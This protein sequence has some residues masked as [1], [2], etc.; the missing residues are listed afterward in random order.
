MFKNN[1]VT[2]ASLTVADRAAGGGQSYARAAIR[3][4][5]IEVEEEL[6]LDWKYHNHS[7]SR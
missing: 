2:Y 1:H 6:N 7:L 5:Q 3:G 4:F